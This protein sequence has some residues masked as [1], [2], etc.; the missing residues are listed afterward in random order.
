MSRDILSAAESIPSSCLHRIFRAAERREA[1]SGTDVV[2]LHVG[3]PYFNPSDD[4]ADAFV[5]A[6]RRGDTKYTGVEGLGELREAVVDKL[7]TDNGVDSAVSRLLITPGSCQG[8]AAL[9]QTLAEPG[10][11]ILIPEFHWPVHLQQALLAG[12]RPVLYPLGPGLRPDPEVIAAAATERTRVL[13]INSPANP[14]GVVLARDE[15]RTLLDL[16]RTRGWHAISD[17]AYEHFLYD[18]EHTSVASLE[19]DLPPAERIVH[20]VFSF[21]KS[22]AMTGYRLGYVALADDRAADVMKVVQEANIIGTSTPV[23]YAGIAALNSRAES[24]AVNRKKVQHSRDVILS[25]LVEAG[26]LRE[27]PAGGWYAMLDVARTG[28]DAETFAPRLLETKGVAVVPGEGFAMRP[29]ADDRGRVHSHDY[30]PWAR[31]LVRI[32]FCV[33]PA[34]LETGVTRLLEFVDECG[35]GANAAAR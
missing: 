25:P 4:V 5:D 35:D 19:R 17:E 10:A 15:L 20:S 31:N 34:A 29:D 12:F 7:R 13:L 16:A 14:T 30:A 33:D 18:S 3:D 32:A 2:K 8:L 22:F 21:S 23:Q 11:E 6:V 28:L 24:T 9:L 1:E 27:L 26:L